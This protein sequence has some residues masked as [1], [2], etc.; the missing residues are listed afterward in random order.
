MPLPGGQVA[1]RDQDEVAFGQ[2]RMGNPEV[3]FL[4]REGPVEKQVEI[5]RPG[6][7]ALRTPNATP[8]AFDGEE[9]PE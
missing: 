7:P 8:C 6:L 4:D 2:P 9:V 3:G 1:E 5:E